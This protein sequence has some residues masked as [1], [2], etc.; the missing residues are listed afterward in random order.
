VIRYQVIPRRIGQSFWLLGNS[1]N[2][3]IWR[4][5]CN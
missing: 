2:I 1:S 4:Y 5:Q 3:L